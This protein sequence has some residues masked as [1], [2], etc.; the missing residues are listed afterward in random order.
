VAGSPAAASGLRSPRDTA[1][2]DAD[3]SDER[4]SRDAGPLDDFRHSLSSRG[5]RGRSRAMF[6][7]RKVGQRN[8]R[9]QSL[10]N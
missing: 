2:G 8:G 3:A 9:L 7:V 4:P 1:G 6:P 10:E 5:F